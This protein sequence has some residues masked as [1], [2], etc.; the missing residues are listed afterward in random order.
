MEEVR[1]ASDVAAHTGRTK[2]GVEW[3]AGKE[4]IRE[5]KHDLYPTSSVI[6][7]ICWCVHVC[8]CVYVGYDFLWQQSR[9]WALS[10]TPTQ[11]PSFTRS[12][13]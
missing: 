13:N 7:E 12:R 6:F 1:T 3:A 2:T 9:Y 4:Q 5:A 10:V 8:V 11:L